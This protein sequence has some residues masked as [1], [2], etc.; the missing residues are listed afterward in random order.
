MAP[1]SAFRPLPTICENDLI[2]DT[3][4][5]GMGSESGGSSSS[6]AGRSLIKAT[7][8]ASA[9]LLAACGAVAV[10]RTSRAS[11]TLPASAQLPNVLDAAEEAPVPADRLVFLGKGFCHNHIGNKFDGLDTA[12]GSAWITGEDLDGEGRSKKAEDE[13]R[14]KG[15]SCTGVATLVPNKYALVTKETKQ[16]GDKKE[17]P[18]MKFSLG[19]TSLVAKAYPA[20]TNAEEEGAEGASCFWRQTFKRNSKDTY[21]PKPALP[22]KTIW[23]FWQNEDDE[24]ELP[25]LVEFCMETWRQLNQGWEIRLLDEKA[26]FD[27]ITKE[28]LP[29]DY[30]KHF[31]QHRADLVRLAVIKKHGGVWM[32]AATC[33][34]KPL[35]EILGDKP[36]VRTVMTLKDY[37]TFDTKEDRVGQE[38]FI[39]NWFLAAPA[40]DPLFET[41]TKCVEKLQSIMLGDKVHWPK[42]GM[43]DDIQMEWLNSLFISETPAY[44]DN[45]LTTHACFMK[46]ISEDQ[47]LWDWYHSPGMNHIDAQKAAFWFYDPSWLGW[48]GAA[49]EELA[50]RFFAKQKDQE[51]Y[52]KMTEPD[53]V[54]LL[55]FGGQ[56]R[57]ADQSDHKT[58]VEDLW[59]KETT[60]LHIF[61][62]YG[63]KAPLDCKSE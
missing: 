28:D 37:R 58:T 55:K 31:V 32:D 47:A 21:P 51:L 18:I 14:A 62:H 41:V 43:F 39:E 12:D 57:S 30:E 8:A 17:N 27:W 38:M 13:C 25:P 23:T 53:F 19:M 34:V 10:S 45:Y 35:S 16:V 5:D 9:I 40:H 59:C 15:D 52:K 49:S 48:T 54:S 61:K 7:A 20:W 22:P 36:D 26:K 29:D 1:L 63:L 33:L 46:E 24:A 44:I 42:T 56:F 50:K 4:E 6:S 3:L 11:P 60:F 2:Q